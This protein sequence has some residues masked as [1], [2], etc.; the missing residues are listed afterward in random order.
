MLQYVVRP[1]EQ[2]PGEPTRSRMASPFSAKWSDT[3]DVLERELREL[4]AKDVVIQADVELQQLRNDG[5]LRSDARP[6]SPTFRCS[7]RAPSVTASPG[8]MPPNRRGRRIVW[9]LRSMT[10]EPSSEATILAS[11][12]FIF[13]EPMKP[14][15]NLFRGLL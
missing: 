12:K 6:R 13:G 3:L 2:W 10:A 14:A 1:I 8:L 7:G 9:P 11:R 5:M 4:R 15:T